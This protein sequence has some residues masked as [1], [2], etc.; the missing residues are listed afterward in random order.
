MYVTFADVARYIERAWNNIAASVIS[1]KVFSS[2]KSD[3]VVGQVSWSK[4]R[5]LISNVIGLLVTLG[6]KP[7]Q[8]NKWTSDL[9]KQWAFNHSVPCAATPVIF[10]LQDAYIRSQWR[11]ASLHYLGSGLEKGVAH[12][13]TM[14][15]IRECRKSKMYN[16]V[17][18]LETLLTGSCWSPDRKASLD[19]I[20]AEQNICP[21]CQAT[22]CDDLHQF[23]TCPHLETLDVEAIRDTQQYVDR[24]KA[25]CKSHPCLWL[26]GILPQ[27]YIKGCGVRTR[28]TDFYGHVQQD[29][30]LPSGIYGTDA[31][32][33]Q[34]SSVP[35][36]RRIGCSIVLVHNHTL[37]L[38]FGASFPLEGECQT[39]PRGELFAMVY[40]A[41]MLSPG[42]TAHVYSDS[43]I[44]VN[45]LNGC[46]YKAQVSINGDLFR[47]LF[48]II[49]NKKL[50][51]TA[52]WVQGHLD[53]KPMKQGYNFSDH[54]FASNFFADKLADIA[55]ENVQCGDLNY[56]RP[57]LFGIKLVSQIQ[58]RI[59][60]IFDSG[61]IPRLI[62]SNCADA[63]DPLERKCNPLIEDLLVDSQH[64]LVGSDTSY[65][66]VACLHSMS[67][68]SRKL[69]EWLK[70][71][72]CPMP[73]CDVQ[74]PVAIPPWQNILINNVLVHSSHNLFSFR[75][76]V[77][78]Y[79]CGSY[80]SQKAKYLGDPCSG[81]CTPTTKVAK[82]RL[83]SR[84]LPPKMA[85]W[86][87]VG[88]HDAMSRRA[89]ERSDVVYT[90]VSIDTPPPCRGFGG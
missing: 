68:K 76:V 80:G 65:R 62:K 35:E 23:W 83:L 52:S 33:G 87:R 59:A 38:E 6:W 88:V 30:G 20:P 63:V 61:V 1:K 66:C 32:G 57:T 25:E 50:V 42:T 55:A 8:F 10:A 71:P 15:Y 41:R 72:C 46:K 84:Q 86:P 60:A 64:V 45:L 49:Q 70:G 73:I 82:D 13:Y 2:V 24:A 27:T 28:D 14:S 54:E 47:E 7:V 11:K 5:G 56:I 85:R 4:V 43:E 58:R 36:L 39:V 34:Y 40:L 53:T 37:E 48:D 90:N 19:M 17:A 89:Q 75:G 18:I 79:Q 9:D 26:R 21:N 67:K 51:F 81:H 3:T 16:T 77:C 44:N 29:S 74:D 78:C 31:S 22:P 12:E 69:K